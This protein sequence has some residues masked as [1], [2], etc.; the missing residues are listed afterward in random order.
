M[1]LTT[2]ITNKAVKVKSQM[3]LDYFSINSFQTHVVFLIVPHLSTPIILGTGLI[4]R[5]PSH[6]NLPNQRN[7]SPITTLKVFLQ[8]SLRRPNERYGTH[9]AAHRT[10]Q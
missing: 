3:Y 8:N 6:T 1:H 5:Q 10:W 9:T 7:R 2:A 4:S